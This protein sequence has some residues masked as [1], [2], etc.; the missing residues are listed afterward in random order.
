MSCDHC[1][2]CPE[3]LVLAPRA[4]RRLAERVH[5]L[6]QRLECAVTARD[7]ELAE[8]VNSGVSA[9]L[10]DL[11]L[12]RVGECACPGKHRHGHQPYVPPELTP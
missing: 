8:R 9:L 5:S 4:F 10:L 7:W 2:H 6:A 11:H 12:C 1:D 3:P